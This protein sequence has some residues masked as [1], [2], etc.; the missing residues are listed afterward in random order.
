MKEGRLWT[1]YSLG[2]TDVKLA[3]SYAGTI[4]IDDKVVIVIEKNTSA[5]NDE[6]DSEDIGIT[7]GGTIVNVFLYDLE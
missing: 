4:K 6:A 3:F 5:L 7:N 2:N 1:R